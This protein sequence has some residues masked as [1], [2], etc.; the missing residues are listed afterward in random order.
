MVPSP[1]PLR[2]AVP[3]AFVVLRPGAAADR[4]EALAL[5]QFV[6]ERLAPYKRIRRLEFAELPKTISGKIRRVE[7]RKLEEERARTGERGAGEFWEEDF[8]ELGN[9]LGAWLTGAMRDD[10]DTAHRVAAGGAGVVR[11]GGLAPRGRDPHTTEKPACRC[12]CPPVRLSARPPVRP[13]ARPDL[14]TLRH[15]VHRLHRRNAVLIHQNP[16]RL[17]RDD[18]AR[19]ARARD[20]EVVDVGVAV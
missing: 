2:L 11:P 12:A 3:K 14:L 18:V 5:F 20:M 17:V 7:L 15:E 9:G 8:P 10:R 13:S 16:Q 6:R 19:P 4:A 1:D